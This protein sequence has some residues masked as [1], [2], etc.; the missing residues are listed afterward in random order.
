MRSCLELK[1]NAK[2]FGRALMT[3]ILLDLS[4]GLGFFTNM[5]FSALGCS[6]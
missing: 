3:G 6:T 4:G 1:K 5:P 2:A